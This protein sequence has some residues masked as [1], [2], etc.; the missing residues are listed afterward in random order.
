MEYMGLNE[1]REKF[2]SFFESK[3]HFR[4]KSHSLVP[5]NDKSLLL[6]NSG[7]APLKPFFTGQETPPSKRVT[8]CQKCIR[9]GDIENVGKTARHGTF[10]EMMGNFS[11]GDYFK[12]EII[13]WSWE[14]CTEVMAIPE[15]R[16]YVSIYQDDDQAFDIW[17]K[18]VGIPKEKIFR[19]GKEDNFW[20]VGLGPCGPCSELYYD[21]GEKYGCGSADCTVGCDC[22]RYMEFWNLVFTQF[23]KEEDGSYS[24]LDFPNIDTG[25][26]LERMA[27][28]MQDVY[29]I[30]DVD[31]IKAV[32]DKVCSLSG[33]AYMESD[34]KDVSI[35]VITD[36][37]RAMTFLTGDGVI[38]S[39]EGRG[40]VLRRLIRRAARHGKLLG[41][42]EAFLT[43][44]C[45]VVIS[46]SQGA[47]PELAEKQDFILSTVAYEEQRF[48]ETLD[49][50]MEILKGYIERLKKEKKTVMAGAMSFKLYDT[51]GFPPDL[52]EEI[53]QE[54]QIAFDE[55]SFQAEM[56]NQRNM[57]RSARGD[58]TFMGADQTV[59]EKLNP[60][61]Q[62][63]FVGYETMTYDGGTVLAITRG[64][65]V[66]D[67][68]E[69]G[70][71]ISLFVDTTPF[72][73]ES[74]GQTGDI[75]IITKDGCELV[76]N[77][78]IKTAAGKIAHIS[79]VKSGSIA[80]GDKVSL[81]VDRFTRLNSARNHS[82]T[83]LLHKALREVLG[84]HVE[85]AGSYVS[86]DKLR[87][88]FTH[89]APIS[90][91]DLE[92][93]QQI[94]MEQIFDALPIET[95]IVPIDEA[96][97]MGA[98]ALFSE[99]YGDVVR[100]VKMGDFSIELCGGFHMDNTAKI[101]VLKIISEAGVA[102]GVRRIE[103]LTGYGVL[104]YYREME[105]KINAIAK[106]IKASPENIK[107]RII[108]LQADLKEYARQAEVLK[109]QMA[110]GHADNL[111]SGKKNINGVDVVCSRTD[112]MDMNSLRSMG[113]QLKEKLPEG[114]IVV[115]ASSKE[116]AVNLV[117]MA[118]EAATAKG[119]HSGRIIGQIAP[120]VDGRGGGRPNMAQAGGKNPEAI[121]AAL[122][123]AL[124][125]IEEQLS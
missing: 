34:S 8:T 60:D 11:F 2:L 120:L 19:M 3:Q 98:M 106:T 49:N 122:E 108:T 93:V 67:S 74:G 44:I 20:E 81:A 54:N 97:K 69:A 55:A 117:V 4:M 76:V 59:Y 101:G 58:S 23:N 68:A 21:R 41:I 89:F 100:V 72:Y 13:P 119:A 22:D 43:E 105:E 82:A 51:Y 86:S 124:A 62:S 92:K 9:T 107:A 104:N 36:H 35:R 27:A 33:A 70:D 25:M 125:I 6:I 102:A 112:D 95:L 24:D 53:L 88:D 32:R 116:G 28:L 78:T 12:D 57:A 83:H 18:K 56:E 30:F 15:D 75:G 84:T 118:T 115:L 73:A 46:V 38:P 114:G 1:I 87:F 42:N 85:Q 110:G 37:A 121:D 113:D 71:E 52:T 94:V 31:T 14:F 39:N 10:F 45:K 111:L 91:E 17:N 64:N 50:G 80:V 123:K 66:V 63:D 40:Y 109:A 7:M 96:R 26:G 90:E 79:R 16:L 5:E 61:M 29:S 103:A 65:E 48:Y 77:D 99:K 47:Y